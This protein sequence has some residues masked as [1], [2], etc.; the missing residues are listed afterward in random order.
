MECQY[1]SKYSTLD[2]DE[3]NEAKRMW[4]ASLPKNKKQTIIDQ[5]CE[6]NKLRCRVC[7]VC[8]YK[9]ANI[10]QHYDTNSHRQKVIEVI[11]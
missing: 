10:Y 4:Y 6:N 11:C 7:E 9:Y 1:N 3:R 5:A 2:E 8:K